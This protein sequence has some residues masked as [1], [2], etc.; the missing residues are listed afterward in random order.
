MS[1]PRRR[2]EEE[3][4]S[5]EM[6]FRA[7]REESHKFVAGSRRVRST[8]TWMHIGC[9]AKADHTQVVC[10][11]HSLPMSERGIATGDST[12]KPWNRR[13]TRSISPSCVR[14]APMPPQIYV[15]P[16]V[17]TCSRCLRCSVQSLEACLSCSFIL[18]SGV[19]LIARPD[20]GQVEA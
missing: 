17:E 9:C 13:L 2:G 8:G 1:E 14:T 4:K 7:S 16:K 5:P 20:T 10:E 12:K 19:E 6:E 3:V 15:E 18:Q 11:V